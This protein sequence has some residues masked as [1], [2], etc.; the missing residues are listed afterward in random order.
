MTRRDV[1]QSRFTFISG[2]IQAGRARAP[3][4]HGLHQGRRFAAFVLILLLVTALALY[5]KH[6][7]LTAF[8]LHDAL[9]PALVALFLVAAAVAFRLLQPP[10]VLA[11]LVVLPLAIV[12]LASIV[13]TP[14]GY[15]MA[16][17]GDAL[18]FPEGA[19]EKRAAEGTRVA[20]GAGE[21]AVV[22]YYAANADRGRLTRAM[23]DALRHDGWNV[24]ATVLPG[25]DRA[26]WGDI[27][28]VEARRPPYAVTCTVGTE[29][30]DDVAE[31]RSL[32][33]CILRA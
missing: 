16:R 6:V 7:F 15:E 9:R 11:T 25:E 31:P 27:G 13:N 4:V 33:R 24:T 2:N 5:A 26:R 3:G 22:A 10:G 19:L 23:A 17:Q 29:R 8:L 32:I 14:L 20:S 30:G 18:P 12:L 28:Y 1:C 21:A